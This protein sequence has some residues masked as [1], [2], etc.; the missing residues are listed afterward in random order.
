VG[1]DTPVCLH[2]SVVHLL[3]IARSAATTSSAWTGFH[4]LVN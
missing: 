2:R 4:F 1:A 3:P